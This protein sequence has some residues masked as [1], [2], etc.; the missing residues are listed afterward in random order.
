MTPCQLNA[1]AAASGC[2][3]EKIMRTRWIA[4]ADRGMVGCGG[5]DGDS[6]IASANA[7]R[8]QQQRHTNGRRQGQRDL[9]SRNA[10]RTACR[11]SRPTRTAAWATN[12]LGVDKAKV[13]RREVQIRAQRAGRS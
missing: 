12:E 13:V 8:S 11:S 9:R 10:G 5:N 3:V 4:A 6:G 1:G 2:G 7:D